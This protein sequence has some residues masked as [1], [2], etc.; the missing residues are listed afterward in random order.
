MS[1]PTPSVYKVPDSLGPEIA[2][3]TELMAVTF[4]LDKAKEF[5]SIDGEGFGSGAAVAIQ[6]VGPMGMLHVLKARMMGAGDIVAL[7][8]SDYRLTSRGNS[9]PTIRSTSTG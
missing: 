8:R 7:D 5:Y 4:N 1:G 6:G 2:V 3:M 9:A